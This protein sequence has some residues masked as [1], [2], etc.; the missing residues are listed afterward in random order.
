MAAAPPAARPRRRSP[1]PVFEGLLP[2]DR[3]R[4]VPDVL[5]GAT[6]AALAI[7]EVLGY[8]RIA[9]MPVVTGLYT[10]IIPAVL[11]AVFGSSR[12]LVVGADSATAAITFAALTPLAL[13]GSPQYIGLAC[14]LALIAG[15]LLLVARLLRLGFLANFLSRTVLI[16]FL[17]GVGISVAAGQLAGMF[18]LHKEGATTLRHVYSWARDLTHTSPSA[19]LIAVAVIAVIVL[20]EHWARRVPWAL[21]AVVGTMVLS[22]VFSFSE[23]GILT[24]GTIP[25][26]LPGFDWPGVPFRDMVPLAGTAASL[27]IVILA[28]SA[29]TSRAYASK[30]EDRLDDNVDLVGLGLA[31]VGAAFTG[32]YVVNGS[33]TKTAIV[34]EA[35]GRSQ[36]SQLTAA[37]IAILVLLFATGAMGYLPE[38]VLSAVV[39][40]IGVKLIDVRGMRTVWRQRPVEFWVAVLTTGTVVLVGIEEG[41]FMAVAVSIVAHIRHSYHPYDRLLARFEGKVWK[42]LPLDSGVQARKGLLI[43]RFGASLYYA[44]ASRFHEEVGKLVRD[45]PIPVRWFCVAMESVTDVDFTAT[46]WL[47]RTVHDLRAREIT[48]VLCDVTDPVRTELR[49]DGLLDVIGPERVYGDTDDVI[50]AYRQETGISDPPDDSLAEQPERDTIEPAWWLPGAGRRAIE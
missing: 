23:H 26:G 5:A 24:I 35:G 32:T 4:A 46:L 41:I 25:S 44:N 19:V 15:V 31:N 10:L 30:Y 21:I 27:F 2:L 45:A 49:R 36:L 9:G 20:G 6:L 17:T 48:V 7:P 18:G 29:A 13:A 43:Y 3:G 28:Q 12:H 34:D 50:R 14:M 38:A 1:L 22:Y 37:A 40:L 8:S 16:G 42:S 39:F 11:F 47:E 33:P